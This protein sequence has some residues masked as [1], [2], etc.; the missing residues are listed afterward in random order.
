MKTTVIISIL[1]LSAL[2]ARAEDKP[3][4]AEPVMPWEKA[5]DADIKSTCKDA[6]GDIRDCLAKHEKELSKECT[7]H[8][9]AAG[10]KVAKLC[11]ADFAKFCPEAAVKGNLGQCVNANVKKLS[12]DCRNALTAGSEQQKKA[13]E[14]AAAKTAAKKEKA[15]AKKEK[16]AE[17]KEP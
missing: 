6:K 17:K 4:A 7:K 1:F 16:A 13:D 11:E 12:A 9:S 2:A 3:A 10:Y 8:F 15:A 5:C 14:K